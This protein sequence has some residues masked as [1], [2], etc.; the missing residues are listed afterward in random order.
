MPEQPEQA[1]NRRPQTHF[2]RQ[3]FPESWPVKYV[4]PSGKVRA[5]PRVRRPLSPRT[6][7]LLRVA[8]VVLL[9]FFAQHVY[10]QVPLIPTVPICK[11]YAPAD[12]DLGYRKLPGTPTRRFISAFIETAL[13][14]DVPVAVDGREVFLPPAAWL[15]H[16]THDKLWRLAAARLL[17][18]QMAHRAVLGWHLRFFTDRAPGSDNLPEPYRCDFLHIFAVEGGSAAW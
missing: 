1:S 18:W 10:F 12:A 4:P 8:G 11:V 13:R 7:C 17:R 14:Q 15:S 5:K 16:D 2:F 9:I 3:R 6:R